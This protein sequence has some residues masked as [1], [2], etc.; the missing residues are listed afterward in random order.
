MKKTLLTCMAVLALFAFA[1]SATAIVCTIDQRPA[2]TLLVPYFQAAFNSDGTVTT[3]AGALDTL[4]TITNASSAPMIAHVSVYNERS[5]LV[6]DFNIALTGFD[7]QSMSMSGV[8][9]GNLP[10]TPVSTAHVAPSG[11][12]ASDVC[13]R[14]PN[15]GPSGVNTGSTSTYMRIRPLCTYTASGSNP[16]CVNT[17]D[18]NDPTLATT[19]YT[20]PAWPAGGTFAINV[21]GSLD[22]AAGSLGCTVPASFPLSGVLR[23]Y[24]VI[25]HVNYCTISDPSSLGG[26]YYN[27]D[28]IGMENNL[29]GEVI[30]TSG[31]GV[32][33]F[34]VSTVNIEASKVFGQTAGNC[35]VGGVC[36]GYQTQDNANRERT[37]Y[38]R[39]WAPG[40]LVRPNSNTTAF[41]ASNPWNQ[42][43]GDER[44]PLG[45]K[46]ATRYF[47]A[48]DGSVKSWFR[49]WRASAGNLTNLTGT[50]A[51]GGSGGACAAIEPTVNLVFY[52]E[53]ENTIAQ[54]GTPPCPSPC[55]IP[56]PSLL[57]FPLETQRTRANGFTLPAAFG[58]ANVGW[59]SASFVNLGSAI[60]NFGGLLDQAWM[61][62]EFQ[63]SGAFINASIPGTQLDPTACHPLLIPL[64]DAG[65]AIYVPDALTD[66]ITPGT[67]S[68]LAT[69][70][71]TA[72]GP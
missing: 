25:D 49:V 27:L 40:S 8:L 2:A 32:P 9:S 38:A 72:T 64:S 47:E 51:G 45:L 10:Q 19:T 59:M 22:S 14:N 55:N 36:S 48:T 6:L 68:G 57:N 65:G 26:T 7:V 50:L 54:A 42:G 18:P 66:P 44:E 67:Q 60:A 41:G 69:N 61:D 63:G 28:A 29:M 70:P 43:F 56:P 15:A 20:S 1:S 39:Y 21:L 24:L 3:G 62:Y 53:D 11:S 35:W 37:F 4:V 5:F 17:A 16:T 34:G 71:A 33:T 13:L 30:F 58:G 23:G 52:D 31:S 12:L 46:Y